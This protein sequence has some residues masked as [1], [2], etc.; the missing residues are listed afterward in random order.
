MR[1][2]PVHSAD[3][4]RGARGGLGESGVKGPERGEGRTVFPPRARKA[5]AAST[6]LGPDDDAPLYVLASSYRAARTFVVE[7]LKANPWRLRYIDEPHKLRGL[8]QPTLY[9]TGCAHRHPRWQELQARVV[10]R[11]GT[12]ILI[13]DAWLGDHPPTKAPA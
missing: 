8:H 3:H 12:L 9:A 6:S 7:L 5:H 13:E 2:I 11:R 1:R 10:E 4:P